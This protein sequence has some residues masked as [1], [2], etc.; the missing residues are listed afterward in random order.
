MTVSVAEG[1]SAQESDTLLRETKPR[2]LKAFVL[3]ATLK[4][5]EH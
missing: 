5:F 4:V 2:M 1:H 3:E